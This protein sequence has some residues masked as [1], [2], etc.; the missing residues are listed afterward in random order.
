[1][2]RK[3]ISNFIKSDLL[4]L[5]ASFIWGFAFVAQRKAMENIGPFLY[6]GIRFFLGA[7]SLLPLYFYDKIKNPQIFNKIVY[8]KNKKINL[9]LFLLGLILFIASSFQQVG[10]VFTDAGKAGFITG[11]YVVLVPIFGIIIKRKT[12]L[13]KFIAAII[14]VVG[15]YFLS[16]K[17]NFTIS[18]G[19][20]L[21]LIGAFFWAIHVLYIDYLVKN[22]NPLKISLFQFYICS[23]CSLL[24]SIF[25]EKINILKIYDAI[26]PILYGG[27]LSVG[28]AYTL[29]VFGQKKA[30]PSHAAIILSMESVFA[31]IG[32]FLILKEVL[33]Y[34]EILGVFLMFFGM[35]FSQIFNK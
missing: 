34:R 17:E 26:I 8:N 35:I 24:I 7:S 19:D 15:L 29:Q 1:M 22:E 27:I 3:D 6:N 21:V 28:I 12:S 5:S 9:K 16:I 2:R 13:F 18:K 23:L 25:F 20:F 33:N 10:I 14:S 32:G 30:H 11:L 4:L 31:V